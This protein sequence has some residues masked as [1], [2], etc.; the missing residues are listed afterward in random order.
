V[1][2]GA[3]SGVSLDTVV[4]TSGNAETDTLLERVVNYAVVP[5][6]HRAGMLALAEHQIIT[7]GEREDAEAKID[8]VTLYR[9]GTEVRL[10]IDHQTELTIATH[11]VGKANAYN[12]AA[13]VATAYV[14][15]VAL[16]T[17]E[18]GA[19][20]LEEVEGNYQYIAADRPYL[21]VVDGAKTDRSIELVLDST[22]ELAK[23]RLI[24]VLQADGI[25]EETIVKAKKT[26]DRLILIGGSEV[27]LPGIE[28]VS[29]SSEALLIA[30]RTAKKDD[31]VLLM[32]DMFA[33][34][35]VAAVEA[36]L[37]KETI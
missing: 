15:G 18:E 17:V 4:V 2:S 7:F 35:G 10:T 8:A 30:Q 20:R 21:I 9:K 5:D 19:A 23:R 6:D 29:S 14:L 36:L 3:L 13:A 26:A 25:K 32:G 33:R 28:T 12:V 27:S 16:D 22:K 34:G 1:A 37:E 31:T 24:A 11:L